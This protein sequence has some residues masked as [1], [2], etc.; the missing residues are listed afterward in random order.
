M[1]VGWKVVDPIQRVG[2]GGWVVTY[3]VLRTGTIGLSGFPLI[4][5]VYP[6]GYP[7]TTPFP[8]Y[9]IQGFRVRGDGI[10]ALTE[11]QAQ[12]LAIVTQSQMIAHVNSLVSQG[13]LPWD[14]A[15]RSIIYGVGPGLF[16][17]FV[18]AVYALEWRRRQI[19]VQGSSASSAEASIPVADRQSVVNANTG[20]PSNLAFSPVTVFINNAYRLIS[21]ER[22]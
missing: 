15:R 4:I 16:G 10:V 18:C 3:E 12:E 6:Q 8:F 7:V 5:P 14:P 13:G 21:V 1:A 22:G 9:S 20:L 11:S 2:A 19:F 17:G